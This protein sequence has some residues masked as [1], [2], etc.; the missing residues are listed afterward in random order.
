MNKRKSVNDLLNKQIGQLVVLERIENRGERTQVRCK[1]LICGRED[2]KALLSNICQKRS[3]K[4]CGCLQYGSKEKHPHWQGYKEISKSFFNKIEDSAKERDIPFHITIE[5]IWDLFIKQDRKCALS[6]VE[7]SFPSCLRD[8]N[9][10][11]S[12]DR[13]DSDKEY[14]AGNIQW[15]HKDLNYMKVDFKEED[16]LAWCSKVHN[17]KNNII[18]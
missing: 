4:S 6:G 17:Y 3:Y 2:Y 1:C 10:T 11:A 9:H 12:L 16:F 13:I 18:K 5:Q 8:F 14:I 7:L 15:I